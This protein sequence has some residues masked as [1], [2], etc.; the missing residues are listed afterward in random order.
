MLFGVLLTFQI[1]LCVAMVGIILVQ[2][3]EGG[4]LGMGGGPSGFMSARGAGNLLTRV[5]SVLAF[6]FFANCI[7]LTI[8]GNMKTAGSSVVDRVGVDAIDPSKLAKPQPGQAQPAQAAPATSGQ[9]P[10]QNSLS[11][12]PLPTQQLPQA[13]PQPV[14][15][16]AAPV[17]QPTAKPAAQAAKPATAPVVAKPAPKPAAEPAPKPEAAKPAPAPAET[18]AATTGPAQ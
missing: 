14:P 13:L 9:A 10:A 6:L 8:A 2:R 4:A 5:T 11:N 7:A 17:T 1:I 3:S 18:P 12:L 16:A 15:Q